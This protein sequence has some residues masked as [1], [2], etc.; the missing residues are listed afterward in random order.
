[1]A[2]ALSENEAREKARRE[3][4]WGGGGQPI[5]GSPDEIAGQFAAMHRVGLRGM[6]EDQP[7]RLCQPRTGNRLLLFAMKANGVDHRVDVDRFD[8]LASENL[9]FDQ[10]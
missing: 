7:Q 5:L 6:I 3:A 1:M 4:A 9:L 8:L 2:S 10:R